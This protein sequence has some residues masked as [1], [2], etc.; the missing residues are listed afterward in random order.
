M[1]KVAHVA[2]GVLQLALQVFHLSLL[3]LVENLQL[4]QLLALRAD[5]DALRSELC[6]RRE[7]QQEGAHTTQVRARVAGSVG[8]GGPIRLTDGLGSVR[9]GGPIRL[10]DGLGSVGA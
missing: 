6:R 10:T 7:E 5:V 3:G 1:L 8:A 9:A 2:P 4:S